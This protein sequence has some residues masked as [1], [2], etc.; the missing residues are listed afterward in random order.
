MHCCWTKSGGYGATAC[1]GVCVCPIYGFSGCSI[2]R[3]GG[4][5]EE[6]REI[7]DVMFVS[8]CMVVCRNG[9]MCTW[10][11]LSAM[12]GRLQGRQKDERRGKRREE[13][14]WIVILFRV[15]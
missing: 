10:W 14:N 11:V 8:V 7:G 4:R 5:Y 1:I 2:V 9:R 3:R 12:Y 13:N 6:T 15:L